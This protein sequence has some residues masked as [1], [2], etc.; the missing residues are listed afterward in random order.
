MSEPFIAEI[1]IW[2]GNFAPRGWAFCNGQILPIAQY[3]A[4]F[5]LIGTFYGG[6]GRSTFALPNLMGRVPVGA[7]TGPGLSPYSVGQSG[8]TESV[9]LVGQHMPSHNH[10]LAAVQRSGDLAD[11]SGRVLAR[12]AS[13][14]TY[15]AV[16]STVQMA[17]SA[18]GQAGGGQAHNNVQ[19]YLALSFIIALQG[20]YPQRS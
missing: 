5:S 9:T 17:E 12:A 6:D 18:L 15:H 8:G 19:P 3:T 4:L 1:R 10:A 16:D 7:G 11:P 14:N 13:G 2:A 20:I